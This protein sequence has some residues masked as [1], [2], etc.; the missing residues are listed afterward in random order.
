MTAWP[1]AA[2]SGCKGLHAMNDRGLERQIESLADFVDRWQ[3]LGGLLWPTRAA[4]G[5]ADGN[6]DFLRLRR[7]LAQ[8]Y[9][10]LVEEMDEEV[11]PDGRLAGVLGAVASVESLA[12]LARADAEGLEREWEAVYLHLQSTLGRLKARKLQLASVSLLGYYIGHVIRS[13]LF[14]LLLL[15]AA[16]AGAFWLWNF[17]QPGPDSAIERRGPRPTPPETTQRP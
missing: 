12:G 3:R 1:L 13:P 10:A 5:P 11:D 17:M 8:D 4:A 6:A 2:G 15:G 7:E 14:I 16:M 9:E